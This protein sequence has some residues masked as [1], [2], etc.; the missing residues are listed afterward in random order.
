[1]PLALFG[2]NILKAL[3]CIWW[4][5]Y[6]FIEEL[7]VA[8]YLIAFLVAYH[9]YRKP[10]FEKYSTFWWQFGIVQLPFY[11]LPKDSQSP[12]TTG[13]PS[14]GQNNSFTSSRLCFILCLW[15]GSKNAAPGSRD[16]VTNKVFIAPSWIGMKLMV[17]SIA[18]WNAK[19]EIIDQAIRICINF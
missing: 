8:V 11:W 7:L 12:S 13:T 15:L 17:R 5:L 1:M 16:F 10:H 3:G 4:H 14:A 19:L 18:L 2:F 6:S 9:L